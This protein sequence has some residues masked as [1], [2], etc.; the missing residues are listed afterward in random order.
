MSE[1]KYSHMEAYQLWKSDT[2]FDKTTRREVAG[3]TD[4]IE[5]EDRFYCD[6]KFGT[7]GL[8]GVMGAGTNRMNKYTV[9]KAT[10]GLGQYLLNEY[11][12]YQCKKRGVVIGYDTRINSRFF[13]ETVAQVLSGMGIYVMIMTRACPTP[14]LSFSIKFCNALAGVVITASH[15]TKEY[16]GYKVYDENGCQIVPTQAKKII[17]YINQVA[18]Y[19]CIN[20]QEDET[21]I[22]N[23]DSTDLFVNAVLKQSRLDDIQAKKDLYIVYTSLHGTGRIPVTKVLNQDGFEH[24]ELVKEQSDENGE[25]STVKSPNPEDK[26]ALKLGIR[27]ATLNKADIVLGT[28]PD[29]DRVGVAVR[30]KKDFCLLSGNQIGALLVDYVLN[31]TNLEHLQSPA[32]IKTIVS[33]E[34]GAN[35][36]RKKGLKVFS[37]LTGFKYIGEKITQFEKAKIEKNH[38]QDYD[39]IIGY[40]ESYGYLIGT[41]SRDKDA[42]VSSLL[43]CEMAATYKKQGKTLVDRLNE[44]YHEYGYYLDASDSFTLKGKQG[45]EKI[46]NI[47]ESFRN[48]DVCVV[49]GVRKIDY[50]SPVKAEDG[51]GNLPTSNV[52]KYILKD[53]SWIAIRPSGTEPKIKLYYSIKANN[54]MEAKKRLNEIRN[55][56]INELKLEN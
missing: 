20:F 47:M 49:D 54:K 9:G 34:L 39:F 32:V 51:F 44:L 22:Q 28:D 31:H 41:H 25:F 26:A 29:C 18:D 14:Q 4:P 48:S 16:N 56:V 33:S 40:E 45:K 52:L 43:I 24:L 50:S 13:A 3:L 30:R 6:L 37:T 35:I 53:D 11:G 2:F 5:I 42:V 19:H 38:V 10:L 36:A 12:D 15:N 46:Q 7:G 8:R 21:L 55:K 17:A 1:K 23:L 27:Q